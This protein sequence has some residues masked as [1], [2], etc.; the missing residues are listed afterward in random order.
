MVSG[1]K[2]NQFCALRPVT[3]LVYHIFED[4]VPIFFNQ[5]QIFHVPDRWIR[6]VVLRVIFYRFENGLKIGSIFYSY[7]SAVEWYMHC[8]FLF[9][10]NKIEVTKYVLSRSKQTL[11]QPL[12]QYIMLL[13]LSPVL[14]KIQLIKYSLFKILLVV[15]CR[16]SSKPIIPSISYYNNCITFIGRMTFLQAPT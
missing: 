5:I 4:I 9:L 7:I 3:A 11:L 10:V 8:S 12:K 14:K 1:Q 2:S 16:C 13:G 15:Q 6:D